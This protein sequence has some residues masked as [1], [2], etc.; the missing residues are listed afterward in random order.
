ML[1]NVLRVTLH[2]GSPQEDKEDDDIKSAPETVGTA[3]LKRLEAKTP[4]ISKILL[5]TVFDFTKLQLQTLSS[6]LIIYNVNL[7]WHCSLPPVSSKR[8][9]SARN[10]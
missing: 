10:P 3:D 4:E 7:L 6:L 1:S 2:L 5:A 9:G 8:T